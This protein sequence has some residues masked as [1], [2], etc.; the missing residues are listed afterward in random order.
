MTIIRKNATALALTTTMVSTLAFMQPASTTFVFSQQSTRSTQL[1]MGLFDGVKEAFSAPA[2]ERST[3][4]S[5]RETPIDRWMGWNVDTTDDE[6]Q[7][8]AGSK[9]PDNFIDSMDPANYIAVSLAKPMGIIFEENDEE[10]GGIF[11]LSLSED[12]AAEKDGKVKPGD[13]LV[14]VNTENVSGLQFDDAL[15]KIVE[16]TAET[17]KLVF[18]RGSAKQ[19]Y[20]P[21]GASREWLEEFVSSGGVEVQG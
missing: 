16:S 4:D 14:I 9:E 11:V 10:Y 20:G 15:G 13:Q 5:E 12:G 1:Y 7:K 6:G 8:V 18:F 3:L 17:T 2:L 21:T 19:F